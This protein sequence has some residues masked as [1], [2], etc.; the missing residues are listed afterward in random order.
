MA[1]SAWG[2]RMRRGGVVAG[3]LVAFVSVGTPAFAGDMTAEEARRF[4]IG[5]YFTYTCFEGTRGGGR[6]HS[7]GS[8]VGTIQFRGNGPVR[9]AQMPAGTLNVKG[10][11]VCASVKGLPIEPCF[12]LKQ[13][14][15]TSFRGAISGLG[16]AYCEFQRRGRVNVAGG[17]GPVS[18]SARAS[19][20]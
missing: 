20:E 10:E 3:A 6:V 8:V 9:F 4:V 2:L 13:T 18:L 15:E 5:K 14:S 1:L 17:E 19:A 16:F 11:R 7:D 12:N